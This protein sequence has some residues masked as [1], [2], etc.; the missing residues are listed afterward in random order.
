[1]RGAAGARSTRL[2]VDREGELPLMLTLPARA[3]RRLALGLALPGELNPAASQLEVAAPAEALRARVPWRC[4]PARRGCF[5]LT[6]AHLGAR[7]PLGFWEERRAV[8]LTG[9]VRVYPHLLAERRAAAA[10]F[11]RRGP[12]GRHVHRQVGQGREFERLREYAPGDSYD[13][14]AWKATARRGRPVTR[15]HQVERTQEVYVVLD[16][17]RLG[18][19]PAEAEADEGGG[20]AAGRPAFER[21]VNAGLI[22]LRAAEQQGDHFGLAAFDPEVRA[23]VRARGGRGHFRARRAARAAPPPRA[24]SPDFRGLAGFLRRRLR[25]RALLVFFTALDDAALAEEFTQAVRLI[26]REHLVLVNMLRP[27]GVRPMFS[28]PA[29]SRDEAYAE[30][31]GH[32]RWHELREL[33]LR[34]RRLGVSLE[35]LDH[36][37]LTAAA[38]S[39]YVEVKRRQRL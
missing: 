22:L 5:A 37:S 26:A 38:V 34:L 36:E 13:D 30:L 12:F 28:R 6:T 4:R 21:Q 3:A 19:R 2:N 23:F 17:A 24:V 11:L 14:I 7:S 1:M 35:L 25:R 33:Q 39:R 8:P 29:A 20:H 32:L 18:A 15:V 9:E 27:A 16:T 10:V 31:A